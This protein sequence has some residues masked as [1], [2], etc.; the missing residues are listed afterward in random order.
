MG[1]P[2][3]IKQIEEE[4]KKTQIHKH[5]EHHIGLL[6]AKLA[7]LRAELETSTSKGGGAAFEIKKG[8][9]AT[10]VLIGLPSVGKSTI[11]NQ[12]TNAK[13]KVASY[14]FTT[15]TVV[16][17]ILRYEGADIQILD[18]PGI[19]SGASSGRGRGRRVLSVA[20]NADLV[21]LVLDV[22]QPGQIQ[23]LKHELHEMGIRIN[24]KPPD[25]TIMKG[26]K[27]GLQVSTS[28]KLTKLSTATVKGIAEAYGV[29]N[30]SILIRQDITDDQLIDV[31][32]GNRK[33]APALVVLNKVDLVNQQYLAAVKKQLNGDF[34]PIAAEKGFNMELL[35]DRIWE[36]L[37]FIR[38][39]LK[40]PDGEPD[41]EEPLIIPAG[42]TL[43]DVSKKIHPRFTEGAKYALVS[44]KSVKYPGQR[45]GLDHVPSDKD[46]VT[47][48]K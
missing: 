17:G 29:S 2:E 24:E 30:G 35:T 47:I 18:L 23:V 20:R 43:R 8:G 27:G 14:A 38:I 28:V 11:L 42:S 12:L 16:P 1:L 34:V 9:D 25:V 44:G 31:L 45:V 46:I 40:R 33:Y 15:L 41:F 37:N 5:T 6:K 4:M 22:F 36:A 19:I 21:M 3:K 10:V 7:R 32:T 13:S 26:H 48:M 39:Y